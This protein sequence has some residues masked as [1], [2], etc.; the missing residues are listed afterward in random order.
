V[1]DSTTKVADL[2]SEITSASEEQ[3]SGITQV[4]DAVTQMDRIVQGN[5][6]SSEEM[7]S[8]ADELNVQVGKLIT[9]VEGDNGSMNAVSAGSIGSR[10]AVPA[11]TIRTAP[12]RIAK[13]S[14]VVNPADVIPLGGDDFDEF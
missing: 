2:V 10:R 4:N 9:I 5:A 13:A 8:Q 12:R 14:S 3:A 7:S 1:S 6:A 11:S